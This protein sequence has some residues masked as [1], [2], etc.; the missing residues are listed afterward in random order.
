MIKHIFDNLLFRL[1]LFLLNKK[2]RELESKKYIDYIIYR[3]SSKRKTYLKD[4]YKVYSQNDED[5]IIDS[6]FSDIG[7]KNKFFIEIGIGNGIENNTH[8]LL[9]KDWKGVW[10]DSNKVI[11][12]KL[13]K[14]L[15]K[16]NKLDLICLK[17]TPE[18]INK[19]L[20]DFK[21]YRNEINNQIPDNVDFM[22]IDIDSTDVFCIQALTTFK[23]RLI[24]I[25]YNS[26][27]PPFMKM[28]I[29]K[30]YSKKWNYDDYFG[31]SLSY[32]ADE[33]EKIEYRLISTNVSGSNAFFV[34]KELQSLCKT[35]N[36][37]INELYM[38]S[39]YNLFDYNYHRPSNKFL[40]DKLKD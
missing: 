2:N 18:N 17:V 13:K 30:S 31:A 3:I 25:E 14:E 15:P 32:I 10:I 6:I 8:Y 16:S 20:L 24:C 22:S 28:S 35:K 37:S 21:K 38:P 33:M 4:G 23:P 27:F 19:K 12:N 1:K 29:K 40:I 11:I 5:G 9:L 26:K 7:I 39:N 36:Q 34:K